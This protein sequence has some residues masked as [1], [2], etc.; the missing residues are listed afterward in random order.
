[1]YYVV[2]WIEIILLDLRVNHQSYPH[3]RPV[4]TCCTPYPSLPVEE[5]PFL[6]GAGYLLWCGSGQTGAACGS[7]SRYG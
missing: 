3:H 5:I 4:V 2:V 6:H 7:A 1:M